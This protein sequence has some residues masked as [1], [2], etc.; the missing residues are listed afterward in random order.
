MARVGFIGTGIMG[1]AMARNLARA[2]HEITAWNRSRD[3]AA[4]LSDDG[5]TI[6]DAA[7]DAARDADFVVAML[8]DGPTSV[9]V[10]F[11]DGVAEAMPKGSVLI[12]MGSIPVETARDCAERARDL[13]IGYLDAPVSGGERGAQAATLAIMAG[14]DD[15]AFTK[16]REVLCA[17]GRPTRVG[18]AGSGQIAKL[19]NQVIVANTIATVA[20]ALILAE[21]GGA[22]P[23]AV[24]EALTGGFADST[25]LRQHGERMIKREFEPG[26]PSKYQLKDIRTATG[27]ARSQGLELPVAGLVE[28]LFTQMV[29]ED[30][31]GDK[32]HSA[33]YLALRRRLGLGSS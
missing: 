23:A 30:G 19:C 13:G 6:V 20:E 7:P 32:D 5:A 4:P 17:M 21:K 25:I 11:D 24:R 9:Q 10:L 16:A 29:D 12:D 33:L 1:F 31:M 8:A 14:G 22:D 15:I 2:G 3:K 18:P 26:G 27:F 28:Q